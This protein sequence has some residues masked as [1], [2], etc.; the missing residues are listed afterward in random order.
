MWDTDATGRQCVPLGFV[1]LGREGLHRARAGRRPLDRRDIK[2]TDSAGNP[3]EQKPYELED[4][5]IKTDQSAK[6]L[7]IIYQTKLQNK[8]G[9]RKGYQ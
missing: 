1:A 7:D 5:L 4:G 2:R 6:I 3:M 8:R 9:K